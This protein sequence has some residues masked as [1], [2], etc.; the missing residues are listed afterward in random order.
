M[1]QLNGL[2][3]SPVIRQVA[4]NAQILIVTDHDS[5]AF[6]RQALSA[7]A[8]G[9]IPKSDLAKELVIGVREVNRGGTFLCERLRVA[10]D[11]L[12]ATNPPTSAL[13]KDD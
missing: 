7:G 10:A 13:A 4:P 11:S 3:A 12:S 8:R 1:P 5:P 9:F 2:A 6:V